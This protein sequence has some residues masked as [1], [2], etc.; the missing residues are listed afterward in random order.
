MEKYNLEATIKMST[1]SVWDQTEKI[2]TRVLSSKYYLDDLK[3]SCQD[4]TQKYDKTEF[5]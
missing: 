4:Y 3:T 1:I 5:V 2:P